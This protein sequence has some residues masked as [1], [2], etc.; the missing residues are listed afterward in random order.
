MHAH[1]SVRAVPVM[2]E[3]SPAVRPGAKLKPL[4]PVK[5]SGSAGSEATSPLPRSAALA[6]PPANPQDNSQQ[7]PR[8][9]QKRASVAPR[10]PPRVFELDK[11]ELLKLSNIN[12]AASTFKA[13][14]YIQMVVRGA[15]HDEDFTK[16][17]IVFPIGPNGKPTF[18]PSAGWFIDKLEFC[19][20]EGTVKM[21]DT[22][23]RVEGDDVYI[24]ARWEGVFFERFELHDFPFD[25]QALTMSLS[26]N[27]R[28]T[29]PI[30]AIWTHSE[31]TSTVV[32]S[33]EQLLGDAWTLKLR[34]LLLRA[35]FVG[36]DADRL[37][38]TIS[39]SAIIQRQSHYFVT[40]G[41]LPFG[42]FSLMSMLQFCLHLKLRSLSDVTDLSSVDASDETSGSG[43]D[44]NTLFGH[45]N[46]RSQMTTM[47]VFTCA[48]YKMAIGGRMPVVAYLTLLDSYMLLNSLFVVL[49]AF[50]SRL[51]SL[52][53]DTLGPLYVSPFDLYSA[54]A[55]GSAWILLQGWF[56]LRARHL[57]M[58]ARPREE[59][60]NGNPEFMTLWKPNDDAS[61]L[62]RAKSGAKMVGRSAK[63]TAG[64]V[65]PPR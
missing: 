21:M 11:V 57:K 1:S 28:S 13:Q 34:N 39:I 53:L 56:T 36:F 19:N 32:S 46:H 43:S 37:F 52:V 29:G 65:M 49:V 3:A 64:R 47:L 54:I 25:L 40:N 62:D 2:Q 10:T 20:G 41:V 5:S 45:I 14:I 24:S 18:K 15:A 26:I 50:Q 42:L 8:A 35:H 51:A 60:L 4:T 55:F 16:E 6:Q 38:P 31:S 7:T 23:Q 58:M 59:S 27:C 12:V 44:I 48:A 30:P 17:G 61:F 9:V 33:D 22:L 63:R